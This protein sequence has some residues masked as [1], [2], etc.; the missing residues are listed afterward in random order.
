MGDEVSGA[1]QV[2]TVLADLMPYGGLK[3]SG[4]GKEVPGTRFRR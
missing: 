4:M 3:E 1:M 2:P